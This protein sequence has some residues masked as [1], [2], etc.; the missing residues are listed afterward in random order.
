MTLAVE[1]SSVAER[2]LAALA[3]AEGVDLPTLATRLLESEA[4][5]LSPDDFAKQNQ[6]TID[7]L[8]RWDAEES[9]NDPTELARRQAEVEEFMRGI[10][11]SRAL[12]EGS[13]SRKIFP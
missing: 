10:N 7:L 9:T 4:R 8:K 13:D 5:R 12:G 11:E 2:R 6:A 3:Q 1:L